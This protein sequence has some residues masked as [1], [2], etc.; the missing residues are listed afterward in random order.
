MADIGFKMCLFPQSASKQE[1]GRPKFDKE[2]EMKL[3]CG[4]CTECISKRAME[5]SV[6][7]RHELSLHKENSFITLTYDDKNL[8]SQ[9]QIDENRSYYFQ[10]FMKRLR[11]K[12]KR[13]LRYMVSHEF[14]SQTYRLHH[15][16]IIFGYNPQN[17]KF[18]KTTNGGSQLFTSD[19]I[20]KLWQHGF[21]SIGTAN[22][23][24]AY[25]IAS[26]AL[27]GKRHTVTNPTSGELMEVQDSMDV[28]KRPAIGYEYFI[29]N[30]S[31]IMQTEKIVPRYY[32]KKLQDINPQLHEHY[33][34]ER[35]FQF[36]NRGDHEIYAK[37]KIDQQKL[38]GKSEFRELEP[39]LELEQ[40]FYDEQL[41]TTRN[42]YHSLTKGKDT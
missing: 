11:K 38:R 29:Q 42:E 31:Q 1:F 8:P 40:N 30:Y 25:Y 3:P 2:G 13:P 32:L 20:S 27:K 33:E 34:N 22:E 39:N 26:Y 24:T 10:N 35:S 23:K 7:V 19:E 14:G 16:V 9:K 4:R 41:K 15:H 5:W 18:L 28:S 12:L 21:H 37:Y 6:R 17:Q 36:K